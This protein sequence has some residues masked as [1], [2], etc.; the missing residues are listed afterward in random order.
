MS[1]HKQNNNHLK[2]KI[3]KLS[4]NGPKICDPESVLKITKKQFRGQKVTFGPSSRWNTARQKEF[5]PLI[6]SLS[7]KKYFK[8]KN[9]SIFEKKGLDTT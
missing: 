7:K 9:S 3:S 1:F 4:P 5:S 6:L 8:K 2:T